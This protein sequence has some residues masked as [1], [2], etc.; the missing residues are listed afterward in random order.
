MIRSSR[1]ILRPQAVL[2]AWALSGCSAPAPPSSGPAPAAVAAGIPETAPIPAGRAPTPQEYASAPD[3]QHYDV[4][5]AL[6]PDGGPIAARATLTLQPSGQ[7]PQ[8]TLDFTGLAVQRAL[9]DG[10]PVQATLEG[11]KLRLPLSDPGNASR[12]VVIEYSGTPDDG[13]IQQANV[14]GEPTVFADNWPNRARFWFPSVDHPSDRATVRF[15]VHAPEAW[16]VIANGRLE[17]GPRATA[18]ARLEAL[19]YP[20]AAAHRT[21]VWSTEVEI[22]AYTMVV[23]AGPLVARSVGT[24]ACGRAPASPRSDGCV[25]VGYWV[26][27]QDTARAAPSFRRAAEMVDYFSSLVGPFPYEKL[28]NVQSSTRFGGM[29]NASA[30]FYAEN[31]LARGANIEGTVSHEIAHQ[32]FGDQATEAEWSHL[33][34]SEGFAT[35][36]GHLFFEHADGVEDFRRRMEESRSSYVGSNVVDQPILAPSADLFAL[37]NANNYPKGGWVLH[38]LRGLLGDEAFFGAIRDYYAAF[39]GGVA[40]SEDLQ[41]V[42]ERHA[43]QPLGWFFDQWLRKPGYPIFQTAWSFDAASGEVVYR[44]EQIQKPT[45]PAFRMPMEL[46]ARTTSGPVRHRIQVEGRITEGRFQAQGPPTELVV[47][48]DGW[49]LKELRAGSR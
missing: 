15:T 4:E 49:I 37:L 28:M 10:T 43:G 30:I 6:S 39:G 35:Y 9:V 44:V 48:P 2:I 19:G 21:W 40:R 13:L 25:E 27:P 33:W 26:F 20:G 22:P 3:V 7:A 23:G 47:D 46:E 16:S 41:E 17:D 34:L 36:F 32:W 1:T 24:A 12:V 42:M 5:L 8:I 11:G 45:W 14:H 31:A 38:M 29:E 18:P